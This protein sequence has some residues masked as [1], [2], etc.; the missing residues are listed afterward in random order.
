MLVIG[1]HISISKGYKKAAEVAIEIGANTFQ[2][3]SRNPRGG[4]AKAFDEKDIAK[5]Q[6][7][8][9]INN[10]GPLLAHAP[11]TMNLGGAKDEV[12][13]FARKVIKEDIERMEFLGVEYLCFHPGSHVGGGVDFGI[14]R[15]V[16]ALNESI[17][18]DEK[19]TILLETMSGKGTEIGF[20]FEHLKRIID[21]VE[22]S[23]RM[24]VCLDTCH[25]FSAGYDI[26]NDLDGVLE[27]FDKIVGLDKL[28]AIHL[29]DSM[30]PFG[31][32]KDRH[33]VIGE[34]K[35]GLDAII[36][37]MTHPSISHLPFFL[38]TPLEEEGHKREIKMIKD[39]LKSK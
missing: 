31:D 22:H 33:S 38:E 27:E 24:G 13:E 10:F 14:D 17:K 36:N 8:R 23:E 37:F 35:I 25:I 15:I 34:G 21:G 7:I 9:K 12:Y 29:N 16:N 32:K 18:G 28:K 30:M 11:Y 6:E 1:P 19:I 20:K 39:I 4:N 26:V 2:F 5:F 3:F